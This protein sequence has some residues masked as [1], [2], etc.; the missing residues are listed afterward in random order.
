MRD[1]LLTYRI[2]PRN[3]LIQNHMD[4]WYITGDPIWI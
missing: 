3:D 2:H 1:G 4:V